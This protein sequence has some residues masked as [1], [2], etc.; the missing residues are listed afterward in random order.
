VRSLLDELQAADKKCIVISMMPLTLLATNKISSLALHTTW[1]KEEPHV[2][3]V[4][5]SL[6]LT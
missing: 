1:N 4:Y 2:T 3:P 5:S 6:P